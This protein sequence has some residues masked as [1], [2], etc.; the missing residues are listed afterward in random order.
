[1]R[2]QP[3]RTGCLWCCFFFFFIRAGFP[4]EAGNIAPPAGAAVWCIAMRSAAESSSVDTEDG[5]GCVLLI[6]AGLARGFF[7][8]R[9][10]EAGG[11]EPGT[12]GNLS[13]FAK[14]DG[15]DPG[16]EVTGRRLAWNK[17]CWLAAPSG[18]VSRGLAVL[19]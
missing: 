2:I 16:G 3:S 19:G 17:R 1:M 14:G 7:L 18:S 8:R 10:A 15:F 9:L 11:S 12:G 13:G 4:E 6:A 5:S